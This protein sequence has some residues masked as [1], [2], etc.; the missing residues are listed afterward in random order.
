M[1]GEALRRSDYI[2]TLHGAV[3]RE[4]LDEVGG[5]YF[6]PGSAKKLAVSAVA[7]AEG[8]RRQESQ[9]DDSSERL[10]AF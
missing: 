9:V 8:D 2:F 6:L 5:I 7:R 10:H 4:L 3:Y 1:L